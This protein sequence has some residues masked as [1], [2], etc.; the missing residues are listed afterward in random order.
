MGSN[1]SQ[2]L[3][4]WIECSVN[5]KH[6]FNRTEWDKA[7]N[8]G[9]F[10][11]LFPCPRFGYVLVSHNIV[12]DGGLSDNLYPHC[13]GID[14]SQNDEKLETRLVSR[15]IQP[16]AGMS[17]DHI[18]SSQEKSESTL[19]GVH[20]TDMNQSESFRDLIGEK[21]YFLINGTTK[22]QILIVFEEIKHVIVISRVDDIIPNTDSDEKLNFTNCLKA[23][24]PKKKT[25][26]TVQLNS[27][28]GCLMGTGLEIL[29]HHAITSFYRY[30]SING[31]CMRFE[32]EVFE[33]LSESDK[34]LIITGKNPPASNRPRG[35][36]SDE[37]YPYSTELHSSGR[38]WA[39]RKI[40]RN[41]KRIR[42]FD[43]YTGYNYLLLET[44]KACYILFLSSNPIHEFNDDLG[45]LLTDPDIT[46][47]VLN[48]PNKS[49]PT[50]SQW[51][52]DLKYGTDIPLYYSE[53]PVIRKDHNQ[54]ATVIDLTPANLEESNSQLVLT[55]DSGDKKESA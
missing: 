21:F 9:V 27:A 54:E 20:L 46:C 19:E 22:S 24:C 5:P 40:V 16:Q 43:H 6:K 48:V 11:G 12:K 42:Y 50:I 44:S 41:S 30:Y 17:F 3:P 35:S 53:K 26:L 23:V 47:Y 33:C 1:S 45:S 34:K 14:P 49:L 10:G 7:N 4:S 36:P 51:S 32:H 38:Q 15:N 55:T 31:L 28:R 39:E 18:A 37:E 2:L 13:I 29:N 52:D 8:S 25:T